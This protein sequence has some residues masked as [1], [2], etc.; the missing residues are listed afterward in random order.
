MY[1]II[2]K[3][4]EINQKVAVISIYLFFLKHVAI[5]FGC[6]NHVPTI[7]IPI[8]ITVNPVMAWI[9]IICTPVFAVF[10][11][12]N[13]KPPENVGNITIRKESICKIRANPINPP[14]ILNSFLLLKIMLK[15][16]IRIIITWNIRLISTPSDALVPNN[17]LN[18]VHQNKI[19]NFKCTIQ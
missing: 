5:F 8:I 2:P 13:S 12:K 19:N 18:I 3:S 1:V 10:V 11:V 15:T 9:Q 6:T 7:K 14:W 4:K 16:K 17:P